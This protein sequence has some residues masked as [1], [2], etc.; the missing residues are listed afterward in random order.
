MAYLCLK[1][2]GI[3]GRIQRWSWPLRLSWFEIC[4]HRAMA[5][6]IHIIVSLHGSCGS[7]FWP[8]LILVQVK[9]GTLFDNILICDDP[10]YAKKFAEETWGKHKD[11]WI[12]SHHLRFNFVFH[13]CFWLP[14]TSMLYLIGWKGIIWRGRKKERRRGSLAYIISFY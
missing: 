13:I 2:T 14:M 7:V 11:V 4:C 12:L 9:S 8:D 6:K 10:E 5:G 1:L 3:I